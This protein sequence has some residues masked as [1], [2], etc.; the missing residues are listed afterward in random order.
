[1]RR[2][3][4]IAGL[5]FGD[6]SKGSM[7]DF[8]VRL[9]KAKLVVRYN[10][11]HQAAH[12]V[13]TPEG[14]HHTFSQFGSGSLAGASTHLSR[15]MLVDPIALRNEARV[16]AEKIPDSPWSRLT[17]DPDCVVVTP[18]HKIRNQHAEE[19]RGA[20]RHGSVGVGVGEARSDE[21]KGLSV[22]VR[23]L[24]L[25]GVTLYEKLAEICRTA[26]YG[27]PPGIVAGRL[28]AAARDFNIRTTEQILRQHQSV[29]FEGAQGV[30]LDEI[31][32][33]AP[34]N[35]WT[36]CT[37]GNADKI[38]AAAG[39]DWEVE[40]VG[41]LRSYATRHGA[42][43][44]PTEDPTVCHPE[45]HNAMHLWMGPFRQGHFDF[46]LAEYAIRCCGGVDSLAITHMDSVG[47]QWKFG[48]HPAGYYSSAGMVYT[49]V[50]KEHV[51]PLLSN[52]GPIR[53]LSY[54]PTASDKKVVDTGLSLA[55]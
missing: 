36:D 12:N 41:V 6:E 33:C 31:Y 7:T 44:F 48:Q 15:H 49:T 8:L 4:I 54:G 28:V 35:T 1:M 30:L 53:Y 16:L 20:A 51:L 22:R 45:P 46:T 34:Y 29:V 47:D 37:F 13:V 38:I 23:D 39:G 52:L 5:G 10:G 55:V 9:N 19:A 18:Y 42:G 50:G 40:R 25:G 27:E 43:P 3:V 17:V 26:P 24:N 21:L 32:G 11:A 14:V 2:A